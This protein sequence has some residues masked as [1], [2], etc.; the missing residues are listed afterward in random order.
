MTEL[1]MPLGA[2]LP[3]WALWLIL[4]VLA[5]GVVLVVLGL[6]KGRDKAPDTEPI[7]GSHEPKRAAE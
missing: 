4:A 6:R 1:L 2:D 7:E 5:A 3:G